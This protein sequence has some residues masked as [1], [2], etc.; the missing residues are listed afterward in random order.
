MFRFWIIAAIRSGI[1]C[2][3]VPKQSIRALRLGTACPLRRSVHALR[4]ASEPDGWLSGA[5]DEAATAAEVARVRSSRVCVDQCRPGGDGAFSGRLSREESDGLV[6]EIEAGFEREGFGLWAVEV[7]ESRELVRIR[8]T[9]EGPPFD[10]RFASGGGWVAAGA[11]RLG[12]WLCPTEAGQATL[13]FGF[14]RLELEEIVSFTAVSN[15]R[16]RAVMERLGMS[17]DPAENFDHP[18]LAPGTGC[19][20]TCSTGR[21]PGPLS[22]LPPPARGHNCSQGR[23][24]AATAKLTEGDMDNFIPTRPTRPADL[25]ALIFSPGQDDPEAQSVRCDLPTLR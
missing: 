24:H 17:H 18:R 15:A 14:E 11:L 12:Q 7:R 4:L 8:G 2:N 5:W 10:A 25:P 19:F 6:E 20:A 22:D 16:S 1:G 3:V 9:G 13:A 21:P 23:N